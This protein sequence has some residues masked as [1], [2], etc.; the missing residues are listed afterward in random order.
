MKTLLI[1]NAD[2]IVTMDDQRREI[3][4]GGIFARDGFIEQVGESKDLSSQA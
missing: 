3:R 4:N 1:K 2:I